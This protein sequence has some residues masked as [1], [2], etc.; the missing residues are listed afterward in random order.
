MTSQSAFTISDVTQAQLRVEITDGIQKCGDVSQVRESIVGLVDELIR[1]ISG[2]DAPRQPERPPDTISGNSKH[3]DFT[4]DSTGMSEIP[5]RQSAG[6]AHAST[7][8]SVV[9]GKTSILAATHNGDVETIRDLLS[10][11]K[12]DVNET[13]YEDRT[14]LHIA[15]KTGNADIV[16]LLL[17][18]PDV[19]PNK[20]DWDLPTPLYIAAE[21]CHIKVV[22][23][24]L[25]NPK[26]DVN[27]EDA[28]EGYTPLCIAAGK[29]YVEIVRLL[30]KSPQVD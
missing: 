3:P 29:G 6:S 5:G 7:E 24:L 10:A 12:A 26:V 15:S 4:A 2:K 21:N 17:A 23:L 9:F 1:D 18:N 13:D 11:G 28:D 22:S 20:R 16:K 30:L 14:A 8:G 25:E 27:K 19:D